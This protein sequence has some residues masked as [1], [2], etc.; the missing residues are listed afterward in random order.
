MGIVGY[1]GDSEMRNAN[2]V[3]EIVFVALF[4]DGIIDEVT[5][6]RLRKTY[7]VTVSKKSCLFRWFS[8]KRKN[9]DDEESYS[10]FIS[11][12]LKPAEDDD[13]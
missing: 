13:D 4:D 7:L 3:K 6:M 1:I 2:T 9:A 5:L 10:Y 8:F 11:K 12:L